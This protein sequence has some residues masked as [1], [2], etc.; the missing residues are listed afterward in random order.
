MVITYFISGFYL[1]EKKELIIYDGE[2]VE[3]PCRKTWGKFWKILSSE[4]VKELYE[5]D[6]SINIPDNDFNKYFILISD[7]REIESIKYQRI[8]GYTHWKG[9]IGIETF[10]KTHYPNNVFIYR[11]ERVLLSQEGD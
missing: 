5:E 11:V 10:G 4:K 8:S 9:L 2:I 7:G 3:S 6:L 1:F